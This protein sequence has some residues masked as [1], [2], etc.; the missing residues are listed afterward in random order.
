[1]TTALEFGFIIESG[2]IEKLKFFN[3]DG[4]D[5]ETVVVWVE[6]RADKRFWSPILL[7]N[8]NYRFDL[9]IAD[10]HISADARVATGCKRLMALRERGE[11]VLGKNN[12]YCLDSDEGFLISIFD[13]SVQDHH[14]I[15]YTNIHSIENA[16]L[17]PAYADRI[18]EAVSARRLN[19][20]SVKPSEL[21][22]EVSADTFEVIKLIS[23][24]LRYVPPVGLKLREDLYE[25]LN[26]LKNIDVTLSIAN[27]TDYSAFKEAVLEISAAAHRAIIPMNKESYLLFDQ[28]LTAAGFSKTN[29]YLFLRGHDIFETT[30]CIFNRL[31]KTMKAQEIAKV[32]ELYANPKSSINAIHNEWDDY[33]SSLRVGF[34]ASNFEIPFFSQT[35][36]ALTQ[37]YR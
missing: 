32:K 11:I 8:D 18:F 12:I 28:A 19:D 3:S 26:R 36:K 27:S 17:Y 29:A 31:S 24:S 25:A 23:F 9:K 22:G 7:D 5:R 35:C 30:V 6:S 10:D 37:N 21:L 14:H 33:G 4:T 15:Y 16:F 1:M 34:C 20:L 13:R 2:D